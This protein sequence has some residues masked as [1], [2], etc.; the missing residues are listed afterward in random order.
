M[1]IL[2]PTKKNQHLDTLEKHYTYQYNQ[3]SSIPPPLQPILIH[4][5]TEH[6]MKQP[7]HL[8]L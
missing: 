5:R 2:K 1:E 8:H 4:K 7:V 6:Q 3:N